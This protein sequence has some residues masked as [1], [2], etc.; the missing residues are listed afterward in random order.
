MEPTHTVCM[1]LACFMFYLTFQFHAQQVFMIIYLHRL[2]CERGMLLLRAATLRA[3]LRRRRRRKMLRRVALT[4]WTIPRPTQSW[5]DIHYNDRGI[6]GDFFRRQFK[7]DRDTFQVLLGLLS[8]RLTRQDT[9]FR[10]STP[11]EKVL[12][13]GILRLAQGAPYLNIARLMNVGKTTVIEAFQ[14]VVEGLYAVRNENIK[15]PETATEMLSSMQTFRAFSP[16]PNVAGA[17]GLSRVRILS[18]TAENADLYLGPSRQH[19][20]II[21]AVTDGTPSFLH[22]SVGYPGGMSNSE[23]LRS[24]SLFKKAENIFTVPLLHVDR[25]HVRPYLAGCRAF[26][27]CPWLQTPFA[28]GVMSPAEI[29]FNKGIS[30]ATERVQYAIKMLKS[31]W[32]ILRKRL[33]SVEFASKIAI[34]CAVLHN[35]CVRFRDRW[36]EFEDETDQCVRGEDTS[37]VVGDGDHVREVLKG[38]FALRPSEKG[39]VKEEPSSDLE[40]IGL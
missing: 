7:M 25:H 3:R 11:P 10:N 32:G 4:Q 6:P 13:L 21:Q 30:G 17:L 37:E 5:F 24:S 33:D 18:P 9:S 16:L 31:R 14:D 39:L 34:A 19:E 22:F 8:P 38:Y 2:H 29:Q 40:E 28:A 12:A 36:T 15:L 26:P 1:A 20:F 35:F 23:V 27:L